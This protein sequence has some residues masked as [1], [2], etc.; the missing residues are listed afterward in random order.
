MNI[1]TRSIK[2]R[3]N[4]VDI[5]LIVDFSYVMNDFDLQ[6]I[7]ISDFCFDSCNFASR[8]TEEDLIDL[9]LTNA[10]EFL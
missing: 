4:C 8:A 5:Q 7:K 2:S 3:I 9:K 1:D 10:P 6:F